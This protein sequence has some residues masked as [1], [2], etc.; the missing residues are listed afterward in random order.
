MLLGSAKEHPWVE[1]AIQVYVQ[2]H[3]RRDE[4]EI[5][6][7]WKWPCCK[8]VANAA[9]CFS[10]PVS[11]CFSLPVSSTSFSHF[12]RW[13]HHSFL[14]TCQNCQIITITPSS[15]SLLQQSHCRFCRLNICHSVSFIQMFWPTN[16]SRVLFV[17]FEFCNSCPALLCLGC[18]FHYLSFRTRSYVNI[19]IYIYRYC[20]DDVQWYRKTIYRII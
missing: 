5:I 1:G 15:D 4:M 11:S 14:S 18:S 6:H 3:L 16:S 12:P 2:L 7:C 13:T 8:N 17:S 19:N 9:I 20:N 10:L